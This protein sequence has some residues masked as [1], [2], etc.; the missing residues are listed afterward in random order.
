MPVTVRNKR[1]IAREKKIDHKSLLVRDI[2]ANRTRAK[3]EFIHYPEGE[4][5]HLK[6]SEV[7]LLKRLHK[8]GG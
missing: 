1:P 4:T 3:R 8:G 7:D 2:T 6:K 5:L